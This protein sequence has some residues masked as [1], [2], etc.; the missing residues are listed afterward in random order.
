MKKML[1]ITLLVLLLSVMF[2]GSA[3]A[4]NS[5]GNKGTD[6][7]PVNPN[8]VLFDTP[9][10]SEGKPGA[11]IVAINVAHVPVCGGHKHD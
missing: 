8:D 5:N 6:N 10:I 3:F 2:V 4:H 1:L 11:D 7:A 9:A